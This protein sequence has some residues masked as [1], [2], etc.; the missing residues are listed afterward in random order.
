VTMDGSSTADHRNGARR[1]LETIAAACDPAADFPDQL[2]STLDAALGLLA[3]EPALARLLCLEP[4]ADDDLSR[5]GQP[6][7]L[8]ACAAR[9]RQAARSCPRA[10]CPPPFLEPLL[11]DAIYWRV[12]D[13]VRAGHLEQLQGLLPDL[14]ESTLAYYFEAE[15]LSRIVAAARERAREATVGEELHSTS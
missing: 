6:R 10:S 13:R 12:S 9:L 8:E 7:W 5:R 4:Y 14:F 2:H 1:L 15:E 11:L 3:S